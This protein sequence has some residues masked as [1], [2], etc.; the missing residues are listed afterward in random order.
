MPNY[1][2][3][4]IAETRKDCVVYLSPERGDVVNNAAGDIE[5]DVTDFRNVC[6][7]T[8]YAVMDSGY[9]YQYD[10]YNDVYRYVPLNGDTAGLTAYTADIRDAWWSPAGF[11]RG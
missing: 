4:N 9:K 6:R 11:N 3:D 1:L 7:S 8:S 10:K 2:I 5:R